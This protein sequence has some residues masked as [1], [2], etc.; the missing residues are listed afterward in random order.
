MI[1][2]LVLMIIVS[3][4][5]EYTMKMLFVKTSVLVLKTNVIK[6]L[7]VP[8]HKFHVTIMMLVPG[9]IVVE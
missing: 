4:G 9:M 1:M 6:K 8:T 3:G 5:M 7:D 2:M